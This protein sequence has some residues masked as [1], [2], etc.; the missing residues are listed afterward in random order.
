[1]AEQPILFV[2]HGAPT[3]PFDDIPAR[4][5]LVEL[6]Q[7]LPTPDAIVAISAHWEDRPARIGAAAAPETIHDFH[8]FPSALYETRYGAPGAP[9]LAASVCADLTQAGIAC[10]PD[11]VRGRDHGVWN[12][13]MLLFPHAHVPVIQLS[14]I[15]S[16]GPAAHYAVGEALSALPRRNILLLASGGA[17]HNLRAVQWQGG[18]TPDW[19]RTFDDW[20]ADKIG[21][22]AAEDL[23][24]YRAQAPHAV[25]AHPSEEHLLPLFCALGAAQ[26]HP[27][28]TL[29]R[30][31]ALGSLSMSAFCWDAPL[32]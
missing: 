15:A 28:R 16:E 9:D 18:A 17:V 22:G 30:S 5:F 14:L 32:A 29:H 7:S 12:P 3:L 27:G 19:A 25:L 21:A 23:L 24:A 1:M 20:L 4:R 10:V 11:A 26:G 2:S 6:G 31:F 13:L 8:G